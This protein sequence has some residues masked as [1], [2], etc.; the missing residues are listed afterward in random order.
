MDYTC[1]QVHGNLLSDELLHGIE[2]D[3]TLK[4]NRAEDFPELEDRLIDAINYR[5]SSLRS[6][7]KH[8]YGAAPSVGDRYG[9]RRAREVIGRF[10]RDLGYNLVQQSAQLTRG[11]AAFSITYL[12]PELGQFPVIVEGDVILD[13]AGAEIRDR[14]S[15]DCRAKGALHRRSPHATMLE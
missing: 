4:G 1:I 6:D 10:L 12:D 11:N 14:C 2:T 9:T 13:A 8:F 15:L 5:W 3:A 7:W